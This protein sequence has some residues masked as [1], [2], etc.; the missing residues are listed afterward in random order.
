MRE[1]T[2]VAEILRDGDRVAGVRLS[3]GETISAPVVVNAGNLW[4]ARLMAGF[5]YE[6]PLFASRHPMAWLR[7]ART[8]SG[9]AIRLCSICRLWAISFRAAA[10][11]FPVRC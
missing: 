5:P 7:A 6:L 4:G 10:R 11:R 1:Q 9:R 3:D 8:I 2:E